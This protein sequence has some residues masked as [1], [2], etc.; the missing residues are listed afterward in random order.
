[1]STMYAFTSH[2]HLWIRENIADL[3]EI[4]FMK[5]I[6]HGVGPGKEKKLLIRPSD[7]M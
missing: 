4:P 6:N 7:F 5:I 1:M 2:T 3:V